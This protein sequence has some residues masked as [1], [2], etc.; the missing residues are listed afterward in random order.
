MPLATAAATVRK[1][2]GFVEVRAARQPFSLSV[3][4]VVVDAISAVWASASARSLGLMGAAPSTYILHGLF[5]I[6]VKHLLRELPFPDACCLVGQLRVMFRDGRGI[7]SRV[8]CV[9]FC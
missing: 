4:F 3:A 6:R 7:V 8:I 1:P 2:T 9:R 5:T